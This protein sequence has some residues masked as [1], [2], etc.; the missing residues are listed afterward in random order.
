MNPVDLQS[1]AD[2]T[3]GEKDELRLKPMHRRARV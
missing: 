1:F 2:L 3:D